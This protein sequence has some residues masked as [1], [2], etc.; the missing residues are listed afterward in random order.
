M[1]DQEPPAGEPTRKSPSGTPT[2]QTTPA[3]TDSPMSIA[4]IARPDD[5]CGFSPF[6]TQ[7]FE[8]SATPASP[9]PPHNA[10]YDEGSSSENEESNNLS[11]ESG[12]H[13]SIAFANNCVERASTKSVASGESSIN[14]FSAETPSIP[15]ETK[16]VKK[17]H[18]ENILLE[19]G[20]LFQFQWSKFKHTEPL[21]NTGSGRRCFG[22]V[23][24]FAS[25]GCKHYPHSIISN[26]YAATTVFENYR[27]KGVS[28]KGIISL[29]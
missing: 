14:V 17:S 23:V 11:N 16:L 8:R 9:H 28:R 6:R 20:L 27:Y 5:L 7:P 26:P 13:R 1:S 25:A 15:N 4:I 3:T 29:Y 21:L 19:V 22:H 24:P 2:K 12:S 10:H 18:I